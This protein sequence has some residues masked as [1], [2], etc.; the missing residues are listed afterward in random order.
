MDLSSEN[1]TQ[2]NASYARTFS[3]TIGPARILGPWE[4]CSTS[5]ALCST[6]EVSL[7]EPAPEINPLILGKAF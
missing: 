4:T 7:V 5:A 2:Y 3:G 6:F 1:M